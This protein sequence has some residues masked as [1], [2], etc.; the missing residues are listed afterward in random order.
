M[1]VIEIFNSIITTTAEAKPRLIF[2]PVAI[3]K[4]SAVT[5]AKHLTMDNIFGNLIRIRTRS[6]QHWMRST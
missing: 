1:Y 3:C 4:L 2:G 5:A 6:P